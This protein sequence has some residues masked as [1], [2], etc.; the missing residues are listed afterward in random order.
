V[1]DDRGGGAKWCNGGIRAATVRD[2]GEL[3][4]ML[5]RGN[6]LRAAATQALARELAVVQH[7]S[8]QSF[9][10]LLCV[11]WQGQFSLR[12]SVRMYNMGMVV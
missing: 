11:P 6:A 5:R 3:L 8:M 9:L 4:F 7:V 10:W 12:V 1:S 2:I